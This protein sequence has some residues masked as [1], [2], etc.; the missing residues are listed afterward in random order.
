MLASVIPLVGAD[1]GFVQEWQV[2]GPVQIAAGY[3]L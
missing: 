2:E 3:V 1:L